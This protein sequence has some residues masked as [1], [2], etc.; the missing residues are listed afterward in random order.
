MTP[1]KK[2]A[3]YSLLLYFF[4]F[5]F[6]S[7]NGYFKIGWL[8]D[9]YNNFYDAVNTG[10]TEKFTG[11]LP[12]TNELHL[13]P[14]YYLSL[15]ASKNIHDALGYGYDDFI[16]Y[17]I[18]NLGGFLLLVFIGGLIVLYKTKRPDI[19]LIASAHIL[20]YPNNLHNICWTAG[21]DDIML[22]LFSL[23]S[24]YFAYRYISSKSLYNLFLS[25]L[26]LILA[27]LSKE[28]AVT[29]P[30]VIIFLVYS[31]SGLKA[32]GM[33]KILFT[34]LTILILYIICKYVLNQLTIPGNSFF[35]III[36]FFEILISLLVPFDYLSLRTSFLVQD[37]LI[38]AYLL[39]LVIIFV[40]FT[41]ESKESLRIILNAIIL[42]LL[43]IL[44]NLM[45]GYFRPQLILYPFSI[46]TIYI[47]SKLLYNYNFKGWLKKIEAY[48]LI[49]VILLWSLISGL[50]VRQWDAT[51]ELSRE[52][53]KSALRVSFDFEGK[54]IIIGQPGRVKQ[55]FMFDKIT[56]PY[57]YYKYYDCVVKDSLYDLVLL[58][59][60]NDES[61]NIPLTYKRINSDEFDVWVNSENQFFYVE[62]FNNKKFSQGII[63]NGILVQAL[64]NNSYGKAKKIKIRKLEGNIYCYIFIRNYYL[65][66]F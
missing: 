25:S 16:F 33:K 34:N 1:L 7:F 54:N 40:F 23:A 64:E 47:V 61:L 53:M 49:A 18:Q 12:F 8:S 48:F 66:I 32:A 20:I 4:F 50:T 11:H 24:I 63:S 51:Y 58:G 39:I 15:Q 52:T 35:S 38:F 6:L 62:G 5:M 21:R 19:S 65:E 57:N 46:I 22:T 60:L 55:S 2:Y 31:E 30:L 17:R 10:L 42:L 43:L 37:N 29:L 9:D 44:P 27:L 45:A 36:S 3:Y 14:M 59:T 41:K 28:T 26:F 56:G 13:R